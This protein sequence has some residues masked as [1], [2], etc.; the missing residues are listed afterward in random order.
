MG[1]ITSLRD[2]GGKDFI[3]VAVRD[4]INRGDIQGPTVQ[5][6][7]HLICM[8][9]GHAWKIGREADG[10]DEVVKATREQLKGGAD[11]IKLM[12][13]GGVSTP[14]DPGAAQFSEAEIAAACT[15]A[16][17][18]GRHACAHA[19]GVKG[20]LNA[21]R[22]GITSIEH[23]IFINEECIPEMVSR[24][25]FLVP[26]FSVGHWTLQH[27]RRGTIPAFIVEKTEKVWATRAAGF[28]AFYEA[29]GKI[30]LGTDAGTQYNH[31]GMNAYELKLMV[32]AGM[33]PSDALIAGTSR[34]AEL[35]RLGDRGRIA[36]G[37]TADMIVVKG[38]P[39]TDILMAA[40]PT[41]HMLVMKGG[42][43]VRSELND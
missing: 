30:A 10:V 33:K 18:H 8:T 3:D 2:V 16:A 15:E 29:G 31:H 5:C 32:D 37:M 42:S 43:I 25:V 39:V 41:N 11:W 17:R 7:G 4:A 19:H 1:G 38:D 20:I 13:T 22:G 40:E 6:S 9:G 36:K 34:A 28:K 26:T 24:N 14:G 35:M 12:A 23:G 21:V 27:A